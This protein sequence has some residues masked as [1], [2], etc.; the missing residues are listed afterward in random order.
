MCAWSIAMKLVSSGSY[1]FKIFFWIRPA[2]YSSATMAAVRSTQASLSVRRLR[3]LL[4][5]TLLVFGL[6]AVCLRYAGLYL[7]EPEHEP[8]RADLIVA[9]GGDTG[10]RIIRAHELFAA[11]YARRIL[12]TGVDATPSKRDGFK[13]DARIAYLLKAGVRHESILV[14]SQSRNTWEEAAS[15]RRLMEENGWHTA[16]VVSD[17]PHMRRLNWVWTKI[18]AGRPLTF[19]LVHAPLEGWNAS[20]WWRSKAATQYAL[21]EFVKLGLYRILYF[22]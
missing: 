10:A 20:Y 16:L 12:V 7:A 4:W 22:A 1:D 11:G 17:P 15:T 9:L 3:T 19:V 5:G 14:D 13:G 8:I 21:A 2:Q 18:C 6:C